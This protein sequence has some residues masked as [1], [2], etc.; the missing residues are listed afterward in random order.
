MTK[1][2]VLDLINLEDSFGV[3][4]YHSQAVCFKH[5]CCGILIAGFLSKTSLKPAK[6]EAIRINKSQ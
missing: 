5:I 3:I 4:N 6:Q 1:A 2:I